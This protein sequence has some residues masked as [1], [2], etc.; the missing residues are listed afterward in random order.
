MISRLVRVTVLTAGVTL[1]MKPSRGSAS[2]VAPVDES[3]DSAAV[4]AAVNA[5]HGS[6]ARS[7]SAGA[8]ALL[9][10]DVMVL[11]SGDV[12]TRAEYRSHHLAADIAFTTSVPSKSESLRVFVQGSTAWT[13]RTSITEGNYKGRAINSS[14]V[15]SM[16]LTK[17][18]GKWL[19][20]SIHWSSHK[21]G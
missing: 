2:D 1:L 11:E 6:L 12:E 18:G 7:D 4:A 5:F 3:R 9:S 20:R 19:I 17:A 10:P 16:I 13:V 15:E 21:R 14:G 8:L